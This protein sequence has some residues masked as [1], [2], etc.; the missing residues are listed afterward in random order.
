M[1]KK[2]RDQMKFGKDECDWFHHFKKIEFLRSV[3]SLQLPGSIKI[4]PIKGL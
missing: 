2:L 1:Q 3:L 4:R